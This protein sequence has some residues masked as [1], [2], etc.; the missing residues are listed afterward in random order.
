MPWPAKAERRAAARSKGG[1]ASRWRFRAG[2]GSWQERRESADSGGHGDE[3][4]AGTDAEKARPAYLRTDWIASR[5]D[6]SRRQ[7]AG[8]SR[9]LA[10]GLAQTLGFQTPRATCRATAR[11]LP[12]APQSDRSFHSGEAGK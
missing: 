5:L 11:Q 12:L 9:R 7:L 8:N 6:R 10:Q 1:G 4:R 2:A 3:G